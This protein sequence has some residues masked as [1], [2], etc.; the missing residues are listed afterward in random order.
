VAAPSPSTMLP[1]PRPLPA[2]F[3]GPIPQ[4]AAPGTAAP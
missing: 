3:T 2:G 1:I 4:A